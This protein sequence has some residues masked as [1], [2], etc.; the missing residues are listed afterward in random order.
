MDARFYLSDSEPEVF[1]TFAQSVLTI[2]T[3]VMR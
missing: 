1:A 2:I 3:E